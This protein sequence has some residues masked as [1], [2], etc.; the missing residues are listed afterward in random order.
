[1]PEMNLPKPTE[2]CKTKEPSCLSPITPDPELDP[3]V[4]ND[5]QPSSQLPPLP[6]TS[7]QSL[8]TRSIPIN[9]PVTIAISEASTSVVAMSQQNDSNQ[10]YLIIVPRRDGPAIN[11]DSDEASDLEIPPTPNSVCTNC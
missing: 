8:S 4:R 1:M 3:P 5:I 2:D 11:Y 9:T 7:M 6:P 10:P